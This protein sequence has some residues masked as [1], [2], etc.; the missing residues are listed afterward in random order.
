VA[1]LRIELARERDARARV[2]PQRIEAG[3]MTEPDAARELALI[4]A[5]ADDLE[6]MIAPGPCLAATHAWSWSDRR[7][8]LV[9]ELDFR[10]RLYPQWIANGR[11][12]Q[13]D[14]DH[15]M[16]CLEALG[17][18]YDEGFDWRA[19]NGA[20]PD[21]AALEPDPAANEARHQWDAH[22]LEVEAR[23]KVPTQDDL[24]S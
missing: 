14:A 22:W 21:F 11:L 10:R 7:A 8:A 19:S 18:V 9:R 20:L 6:R 13:A 5:I 17:D 2:Y 4:A 23:R 15:R 12:S 16:A 24:F 3:R 1:E